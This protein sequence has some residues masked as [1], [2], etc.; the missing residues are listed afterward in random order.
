VPDACDNCPSVANSNQADADHDGIGDACDP[1]TRSTPAFV[2]TTRIK[3]RVTIRHL[4]T[5]PGDDTFNFSGQMIVPLPPN[6]PAVNPAS[7]GV[8]ILLH[9]SAGGVI[10]DATI[11]GGLYDSNS[12]IGW[13]LSKTG[14]RATYRNLSTTVTPIDGIVRVSIVSSTKTIGLLKVRVRGKASN[15][16]VPSGQSVKVTIVIDTPTAQSGQCGEARYP[17]PAPT[18][19]CALSSTGATLRCK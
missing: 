9:N 11:P 4:N 15:Y 10:F 16:V 12:K 18:P 8:R 7:R 14:L 5:P 2:I 13:T 1:C 3:P 17:G 6:A 19:A